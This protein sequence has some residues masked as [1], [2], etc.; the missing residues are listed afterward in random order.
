MKNWADLAPRDKFLSLGGGLSI[1]VEPVVGDLHITVYRFEPGAVLPAHSH[2]PEKNHISIV[3]DGCLEA[4]WS[5][6]ERKIL[7]SGSIIDLEPGVSHEFREISNCEAVLI[8]I[9]RLGGTGKDEADEMGRI[10]RLFDD[11]VKGKARPLTEA[12]LRERGFV[13][14]NINRGV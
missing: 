9:R 13:Y 12:E 14:E 11:L 7:G 2:T 6:N 4:R 5:D 8:N 10:G 3:A 1:Y